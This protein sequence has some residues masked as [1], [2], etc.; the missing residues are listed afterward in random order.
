MIIRTCDRCGAVCK[1]DMSSS[2][3]YKER[4]GALLV[5][6]QPR[7]SND[8]WYDQNEV[9]SLCPSCVEQ[10]QC[11]LHNGEFEV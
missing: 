2:S 1:D 11:W 5:K 6:M 7:S 10:L 9:V 3:K 8:F 4:N